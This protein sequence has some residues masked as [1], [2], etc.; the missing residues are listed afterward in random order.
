MDRLAVDLEDVDQRVES[1]RA[2]RVVCHWL[3]AAR[4]IGTEFNLGLANVPLPVCAARPESINQLDFSFRIAL[5][6]V[7]RRPTEK[8]D[9]GRQFQGTVEIVTRVL[10]SSTMVSISQIWWRDE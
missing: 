3:Q 8:N 10:H 5:E 9:G 6:Q 1:V 4:E 2:D 7:E